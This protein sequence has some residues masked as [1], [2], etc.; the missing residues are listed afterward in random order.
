M[1]AWIRTSLALAAA[2]LVGACAQNAPERGGPPA[3][4]G[5][6]MMGQQ[7]MGPGMMGHQGMGPG[8]AAGGPGMGAMRDGA[9]PRGMGIASLTPMQGQAVQGLV[10]FHQ[11]GPG[12][13]MVHARV[14][15]LKPNAE[16]GF[17]VHENGNCA[18]PDGSS[19]GGHFNPAG[20]PHGPQGAPHHAGD[21]PSLKADAQG[22]ADARFTL[23]GVS[24]GSGTADLSGRSVVVHANPDD[25][26][27]QPT[28]N[29]GGRIACGVIARH[30]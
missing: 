4:M 25:Y 5:P 14:T 18:S 9:G 13:V 3:G 27:T 10:M 6:G 15:G 22:V 28:G 30:P 21:M 26:A 23:Q 1:N 8:A 19:A 12:Q 11:G 24:L 20:A 16:H 29:S 2:A 17:H 7:G